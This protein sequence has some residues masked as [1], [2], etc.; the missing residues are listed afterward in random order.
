MEKTLSIT[1]DAHCIAADSLVQKLGTDAVAGLSRTETMRRLDSEGPNRLPEAGERSNLKILLE[2][3][4]NPLNGILF[5]AALVSFI[6]KDWLE[7]F[8]VLFVILIN[9]SIAWWMEWQAKQSMRA[10]KK[11]SGLQSKVLREESQRVIPAADLVPGDILLLEAGDVIGADARM[12]SCSGLAVSEAALTGESVPVDK[13]TADLP[14]ETV[15][16][17]QTNMVFKGTVVTRGRGVA[18]V[19]ATGAHTRLGHIAALTHSARSEASPLQKKLESLSHTLMRLMVWL[20]LLIAL[21]GIL[22]GK[23][24]LLMLKTAVALAVAAIPEGLPIVATIALARGMLSLARHRVIVKQLN[25]V[26]TLGGTG[27]ILTDKTGTLTYNKLSV[28]QIV[29]PEGIYSPDQPS[30]DA[31]VPNHYLQLSLASVLC[32]N[33][34]VNSGKFTGDPIE[35]ALL[36]WADNLGIEVEAIRK[37]F[38]RVRDWPFESAK[39]WMATAHYNGDTKLLAVKGAIEAVL[40]YCDKLDTA[41][42][43]VPFEDKEKVLRQA[44]KLAASGLRTLAFASADVLNEDFEELPKL[45]FLGFIAFLDPPRPEVKPAIHSCVNAGIQVYMVT[46]DHPQT[47]MNIASQTGLISDSDQASFLTGAALE[48]IFRQEDT[49]KSILQK[50]P[51]FARVAPQHKLQLVEYFQQQGQV[52]AM[53]GDGINDMPALKKADIGIAMGLRGTEA[54]REVADMVLK[55]DSFASIVLAIKRGRAIFANIR[56][57]VVY[58]LSCNLAELMVISIAAFVNLI[59]PLLP[60]QILFVNMVTDVFPALALGMNASPQNIMQVQPRNPDKP[61]LGQ[62]DWFRI[63]KFSAG[64]SFAT[65]GSLIYG[66]YFL[67]ASPQEANNMAFYTLILAQLLQV[68]NLPEG[69]PFRNEVSRNP[70]I[71]W[72]IATGITV[73]ALAYSIPLTRTALQ[74]IPLS[75]ETYG[76]IVVFSVLPTLLIQS[77]SLLEYILKAK[78]LY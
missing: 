63:G 73:T 49:D 51:V 33:A 12:L 57:F 75:G 31:P 41:A 74:L 76:Y 70:Y 25:A 50:T 8:A 1:N 71:W 3:L 18:L 4:I 54:A 56:H 61:I 46:G 9:T 22:Q 43:I 67:D 45:N 78:T 65:L 64:I 62:R 34:Q 72:S 59:T 52:V 42:G 29:L 7:S 23:D 5:L 21:I 68:F 36:E 55:D 19:T 60:L 6:F 14:S 11:L 13:Q 17:D 39:K 16:A 44:E 32:N 66:Y 69:N 58:L 40:P 28:A 26:E 37:E 30:G 48:K 15:M 35:V 20:V 24:W 2:Q 47:A 10:L 27:I 53:T 38:P 77:N